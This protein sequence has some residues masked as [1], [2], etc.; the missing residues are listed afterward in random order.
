ME[1][2]ETMVKRQLELRVQ[3]GSLTEKD[4]NE[5]SERAHWMHDGKTVA[6]A[7][8]RFFHGDDDRIE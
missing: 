5:A 6:K 3:S 4:A 8:I 2:N 7:A 1:F